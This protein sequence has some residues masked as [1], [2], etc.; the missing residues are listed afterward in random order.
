MANVTNAK[1]GAV[2]SEGQLMGPI[3]WAP[4]GTTLP[5]SVSAAL[6]S[7]FKSLGYVS[8][9][10]VTNDNSPE[11]DTVKA[12]GGT[13]VLNMQT[14]RPDTFGF[15]MLEHLNSDLLKV[16]YGSDNVTVGEDGEISVS[17]NAADMIH[18]SWVIDSILLDGK[19][20]RVV[21]PDGV[22]SEIGTITRSDSE[23]IGYELTV[24][25]IPDASGNYHYNY[26]K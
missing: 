6:D 22:I 10:G 13:T 14:D 9:D 2:V 15:T 5:T 18:G 1:S 8:E 19:K 4:I 11:S 16:I 17:V 26:M 3:Y 24:T 25:A 20:D 12:W 7:A 23:P 21:I